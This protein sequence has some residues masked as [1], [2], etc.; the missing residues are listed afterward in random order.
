MVAAG[1]PSQLD[2]LAEWP[3]LSYD[4]G[5]TDG[6]P[7]H[8]P[9]RAAV[10]RLIAATGRDA[11]D[12]VGQIPPRDA[13]ATIEVVAANAAMA[14]ARPE[15]MPVIV[16][17]LEAMLTGPF[18]LRGVQVTTHGCWPLVIV[19]GNAVTQ[20]GMA[21]AESVFSG[22][23]SRANATIG[24]AI[25]LVL[26][27]VGGSL[28]GEP[29][30]EVYGQPGRYSF[31]IAE[32]PNSP[33]EPLHVARGV[34]APSGVT[35]CAV[36]A[37]HS[38]AMW[39]ANDVAHDRLEQCADVMRAKGNNNTHTMGD[40]VVCVSPSEAR[41]LHAQGLSRR[42]VQD[43]LF[44][45]ARRRIDDLRPA[46]P[47][48]PNNEPQHH[49]TWWPSWVDQTRDDTLVPVVE[50]PDDVHVVVCGADSI[51]WWAVCP[52]WGHLGGFAETR[53]LELR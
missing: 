17:A 9:L 52:G 18:N 10:D 16:T 6:L 45:L 7:V 5:L 40:V 30:K 19:S 20:L 53:K 49:Y 51:P 26:W 44:K 12:I 32:S 37:P 25:R 34:D 28:P 47:M 13:T 43:E 22:G 42:D 35:V 4:L 36:E 39:G 29:V 24:R 27:N 3:E 41:A 21:H 48:R 38:V 2:D 14:G 15:Y 46:G 23:G 50:R 8:P 11:D 31:C 1:F 33:W